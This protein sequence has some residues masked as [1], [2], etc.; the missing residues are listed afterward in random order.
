MQTALLFPGVLF[1]VVFGLNF[2]VWAKASSTALPFGTLLGL[3]AL[4]LLIQLP[5]VYVGAWYGFHNT[6]AFEHPTKTNST[7]RQ[8][9]KQL[10]YSKGFLRFLLAGLIPFAVIFIE[11]LFIF[12]NL[13]QDKSG[14]YYAFGFLSVVILVYVVTVIEVTIITIY[15]QLCA[16]VS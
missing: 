14:Y 6:L 10:W 16:E 11:L 7:P 15:I 9:P 3:I 2:F 13:W 1:A 5:L 12:R 8:I 4:W